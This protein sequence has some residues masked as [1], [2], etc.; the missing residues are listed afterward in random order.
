[1]FK[2]ILILLLSSS[3]WA[4]IRDIGNGGDAVVCKDSVELLD[5][6]EARVV[7]KSPIDLGEEIKDSDGVEMA[8]RVVQRMT[9]QH[10][11]TAMHYRKRISSFWEDARL[12]YGIQ[13][14]DIKDENIKLI[15]SGNNE[16][17]E[18]NYLLLPAGCGLYQVAIRRDKN[19]VPDKKTF[20]INGDLWKRMSPTHRAGL[21]LHEVLYEDMLLT[22]EFGVVPFEHP[23]PDS[24][25]ARFMNAFFANPKNLKLGDPEYLRAKFLNGWFIEDSTFPELLSYMG[26]NARLRQVN[27]NEDEKIIVGSRTLKALRGSVI[28]KEGY[29]L[30]MVV[31]EDTLIQTSSGSF[32]AIAGSPLEFSGDNIMIAY[33]KD[34]G[35]FSL[36]SGQKISVRSQQSYFAVPLGERTAFYGSPF[37]VRFQSKELALGQSL[38][39][40]GW[41]EKFYSSMGMEMSISCSQQEHDWCITLYHEGNLESVLLKPEPA[42]E[43]PIEIVDTKGNKIDLTKLWKEARDS[44]KFRGTPARRLPTKLNFNEQGQAICPY[45]SGETC[46]WLEVIP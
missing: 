41:E 44:H 34:G 27:V 45:Q 29:T 35:T 8:L 33:L 42:Q 24:R 17:L 31:A 10:P 28:E 36:P 4:G 32:T 5:Y 43:W 15:K 19:K 23:E 21:I 11:I 2:F 25:H 26:P 18:D 37:P 20:S 39:I 22:D 40:L 12:E 16:K 3:S 30:K 1:M 38:L 46:E 6:Y 13:L 9:S 14:H 7:L